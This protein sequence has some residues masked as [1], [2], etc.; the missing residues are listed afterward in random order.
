[1]EKKVSLWKY[2]L[3]LSVFTLLAYHLPFFQ[4]LTARLEGGV[5]GVVLQV[6][7]ALLLLILDFFLYYVLVF[8][9]RFV[10]KCIVAFT[11]FGD[12]VMLYFVNNYEVLVTDE[13][14]GNVINTQY[15]EAS[16]FFSWAFVLYIIGLCV[17]PCIYVFGR[18]VDYGRWKGFFAWCG[19]AVAALVA[20]VFGNMKNWPWIDRNSTELGSLLMPWSYTV[21]TF[22]Y[23][24]A[25][26]K[27]AAKEILLPDPTAVSDSRD[28]C[29]LFIGESVR[30]DHFSLYG[31][32]R[33]T[34][35]WTSRDG[36]KAYIADASATYTSAGVK[37]ILEYKPSGKLY[38][39]LP[40]YLQRMGADVSWRTSNW[41]EPPVHTPKY[42]K[43]GALKKRFPSA[44]SHFDGILLEGL[45]DDILESSADKVFIVIHGYTN[46]GPA[47][48]TNYPSRF[49]VFT[50]VCNTVEMSKTSQ[51]ELFNAYDNS[52]VYTDWLIHSVIEVLRSVPS[53]R[54]C[55]L[56]VSDHGESLGENNLYMH[57]VPMSMAPREQIEIPFVVW[58]SDRT[59][60][61]KDLPMVG[62][63]SVFHTVLDFFGV[64]SPVFDEKL[65]IFAKK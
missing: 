14:M 55:M 8:L 33:E 15:S 60:E 58:T 40:N 32:P 56:F 29:V 64:E 54:S 51:E 18:K 41:G 1:M 13:M 26:K 12:A 65:S 3:V 59:L 23:Y 9:G 28:V 48:N 34:N 7:A 45:R 43:T 61:Y 16:G 37:A 19:I 10:G 46:H 47:Y 22:R 57:G 17:V 36:V 62:Q 30:R 20:V 52:I 49:E 4:H 27:K 31:Y 35:P 2:C 11:L 39:I 42:Y 38:E 53:R 21:N 6:S 25:K 50:P 24:D 44:D 5:N 63:H